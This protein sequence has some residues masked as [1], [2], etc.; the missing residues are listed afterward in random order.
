MKKIFNRN[1]LFMLSFVALLLVI[2]ITFS[3]NNQSNIIVKSD[4]DTSDVELG[5]SVAVDVTNGG[6]NK[7]NNNSGTCNVSASGPSKVS[8]GSKF[9]ITFSTS[10]NGCNG[11]SIS[12]TIRGASP[13]SYSVTFSNFTVRLVQFTAGSCP[14]PITYSYSGGSGSIE[15]ESKFSCQSID[16][17]AISSS[18]PISESKANYAG[19]NYYYKDSCKT[20]DGKSG[21]GTYCTRECGGGK[22]APKAPPPP[23]ACWAN[24]KTLEAA[25]VAVWTNNPN[26]S[27]HIIRGMTEKTCIPLKV[28]SFCNPT[29]SIKSEDADADKCED[30]KDILYTDNISCNGNSFYEIICNNPNDK[31]LNNI[32]NVK[33]DFD[34]DNDSGNDVKVKWVKKMLAGDGFAFGVNVEVK[35]EC[36]ATFNAEN[37]NSAYK[38]VK[39]NYDRVRANKNGAS[40]SEKDILERY[41]NLFLNQ[42]NELKEFVNRYNSYHSAT[43]LNPNLVP[44]I[45]FSLN[46]N[47]SG[48]STSIKTSLVPLESSIVAGSGKITDKKTVSLVTSD[49]TSPK[50]FIWSNADNPQKVKYVFQRSYLE[51]TTGSITTNTKGIDGGNK[52]YIDYNADTEQK[53]NQNVGKININLTSDV[54]NITNSKCEI[55]VYN[56]ELV[57]RPISLTNPFINSEHK[58]G[59][60]WVNSIYDFTK[61]IDVNTW[62]KNSLYDIKLSANQI[63]ELKKSNSVNQSSLP[64]RGL[65]DRISSTM[66][67]SITKYICEKLK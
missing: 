48:K 57:Y 1:L 17:A 53:N 40:A 66:Q 42:M 37:W 14:G 52:V 41:E 23:K 59:D 62:S 44:N 26:S 45:D 24:A 60:N 21:Y 36:K 10:G 20:L 8:V 5:E 29:K 15:V 16:C 63:A 54:A 64:Y 28:P 33:Y 65:C 34:D 50:N 6:E 27:Y 19:K 38:I 25:T 3:R 18:D 39:A 30:N 7:T 51:P 31:S 61:I 67:D 58:I 13:G 56:S 22:G 32:V 46:Y 4:K 12:G 43:G 49:V 35:K 55:K 11:K 47:V 2:E 9:Y